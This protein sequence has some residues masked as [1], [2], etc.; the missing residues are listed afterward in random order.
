MQMWP[1]RKGEGASA[2]VGS[3]HFSLVWKI[4]GQYAEETTKQFPEVE[5]A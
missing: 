1:L 5:T 3:T 4:C 2:T